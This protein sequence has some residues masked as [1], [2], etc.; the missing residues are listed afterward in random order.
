MFFV[1]FL[2][3]NVL[4][5]FSFSSYFLEQERI[6]KNHKQTN[7]KMMLL[8]FLKNCSVLETGTKRPGYFVHVKYFNPILLRI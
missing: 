4:C 1:L 6:F 5:V 8:I 2:R 7:P 3:T